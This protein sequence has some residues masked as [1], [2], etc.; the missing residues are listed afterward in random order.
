VAGDDPDITRL[1]DEATTAASPASP[2]AAG[3]NSGRSGDSGTM[4]T[5]SGRRLTS[6]EAAIDHG[7]FAPGTI[8][9]GRYRMIGRLGAGGM[10]EVYRA[11]DLKLGQQVALKFLPEAVDKDPARLTQLHSEVRISRQIS[12]P[13]VCRVYDI[14]EYEGHTFLSMEYVDGEDLASLL[15]RVGRLAQTRAIELTR[16]ICAGLA[17]AHDRGVVHRDLKPPNIMLDGAGQIRITDFGLA[18]AI[19]ESPRAGTP[20]YMAPEQL[21]GQTVTP[22]SDL[23]ALGLVLYELFT[24]ERAL[25]A[26]NLAELIAKREQVDITPPTAVVRELDPAIE[27]VI[28]RCLERDPAKR[29]A[30]ALAV[31]AALPGGDPLA[32]ALLAGTTPSPDAVAA[33]GEESAWALRPALASVSFVILGLIALV[34]M[35]DRVL[36]TGHVAMDAPAVVMQDRAEQIR[37]KLGYREPFVDSAASFAAMPGYSTFVSQPATAEQ[38]MQRVHGRPIPLVFWYR[39]SPEPLL[40]DA[41]IPEPNLADPP[42]LTSGMTITV[43]DTRGRL[44]HFDAVPPQVEPPAQASPSPSTAPPASQ[45]PI[46]SPPQ[47]PDWDVLFAA[48]DIPRD[49]FTPVAPAWTPLAYADARAAWEGTLAE[50]PEIKLRIEA[51]GYRGRVSSFGII[52]P[53]T[54]ATR[55]PDA[56]A[57]RGAQRWASN[58]STLII[59][60][61]VAGGFIIGRHN[62]RSGRGDRRGAWRLATFLFLVDIIRRA[63]MAAHLSVLKFDLGFAYVNL[64]VAV[65]LA[66]MAWGI[67]MALEPFVRRFWPNGLISWTRLLSGHFRDPRVGRDVLLGCV[68]GTLMA[69]ITWGHNLLPL[70]VGQHAYPPGLPALSFLNGAIGAA[71]TAN[72]L[73]VAGIFT[74]MANIFAVV[75]LRVLLR[76]TWL[77]ITFAVLIFS[78]STIVNALVGHPA[79]LDVISSLTVTAL[80]GIVVLRFGVL[81]TLVAFVFLF[82]LQSAPLTADVG[83][84]FFGTSA[85]IVL[86]LGAIAVAAFTW[87][88]AGEPL[89]GRPLLD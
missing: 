28:L 59:L 52:G 27:R 24:G 32:A 71:T 49:R 31:A 42:P 73:F 43:V 61:F 40:P 81:S 35:G 54:P 66:V 12:H 58:I 67:Y 2:A 46:S 64:A 14:D 56:G 79:W 10:G 76:R 18:G 26:N 29:P 3:S 41:T 51:A 69:L 50:S 84:W 34:A 19:G 47:A 86:L 74:G 53:W 6:A 87:A 45:A 70:L 1:G 8:I 55:M 5:S 44:V 36:T 72:R 37:Q 38:I 9:G 88:R 11:D 15:R 60:I 75:L 7:R 68:A 62:V 57:A 25:T 39:T 23:Y 65:L 13:H 16:Q 33:A 48:A 85:A 17:A 77:V 82:S 30:S 63:L 21:A 80:M 83:K 20:A 89:F 22:R 4:L 78:S